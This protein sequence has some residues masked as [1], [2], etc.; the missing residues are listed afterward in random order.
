MSVARLA[1]VAS[2]AALCGCDLPT[3]ANAGALSQRPGAVTTPQAGEPGTSSGTNAQP[4]EGPIDKAVVDQALAE[5]KAQATDPEAALR[6]WFNALILYV[7]RETRATGRELMNA[8]TAYE[9]W[10]TGSS[11][12]FFLDRVEIEPFTFYSYFTGTSPDNGYAFDPATATLAV[13]RHDPGVGGT[14]KIFVTSSGADFP[15]PVSLKLGDDGLYRV[16]EFSSIYVG[17]RKP[18]GS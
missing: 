5:F 10:E 4:G 6:H 15:R 17:V 14:Y 8:F 12:R 11:S 3:L 18:K 9:L 2:L 16:N 1:L 13:N 7:H